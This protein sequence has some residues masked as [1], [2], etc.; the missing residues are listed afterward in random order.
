MQRALWSS[1][2]IGIALGFAF[3]REASGEDLRNLLASPSRYH[4]R[5]VTVT[6]IARGDTAGN[7]ML[8]SRLSDALD[9]LSDNYAV[10]M[11]EDPEKDKRLVDLRRVRVVG[12]VNANYHGVLGHYRCGI[13]IRKVDV[14]SG[15]VA[16]WDD[17]VAVFRNETGKSIVLRFGLPPALSQAEVG[18]SQCMPVSTWN[19][20]HFRVTALSLGGAEITRA[21]TN[22]DTSSRFYD[23]A[24]AAFYYRITPRHIEQVTPAEAKSWGWRR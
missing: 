7:I 23:R 17:R 20:R 24:N 6:G 18:A 4:Q 12:V 19:D 11:A 1:V 16:P 2:T 13:L 14:L 5:V 21:D 15:P 10:A 3:T 8:F 22:D 9:L